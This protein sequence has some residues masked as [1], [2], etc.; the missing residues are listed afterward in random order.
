MPDIYLRQ[1]AASPS[2]I[3]LRDPTIPDS[4]SVSATIAE[5]QAAQGEAIAG[6]LILQA[7]MAESQAAQTEAIGASLIL[8][9][10]I[11]ES[12]AAQSEAIAGDVVTGAITAALTEAQAAQ[13]EAIAAVNVPFPVQRPQQLVGMGGRYYTLGELLRMKKRKIEENAPKSPAPR[14]PEPDPVFAQR[15]SRVGT[16]A[17]RE[18]TFTPLDL[19]EITTTVNQHEATAARRAVRRRREREAV[20][21]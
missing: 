9:A 16:R 12:Q 20:E 11:A 21:V 19:S 15:M 5:A 8:P 7:T 13:A 2:D 10:A 1:G 18:V 14:R 3:I 17:R 4:T 6:V